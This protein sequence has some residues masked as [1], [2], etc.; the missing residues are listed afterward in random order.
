MN[1]LHICITLSLLSFHQV[2]TTVRLEC[3]SV[4][5]TT[6]PTRTW[7]TSQT[8]DVPSPVGGF[9]FFFIIIINM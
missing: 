3:W 7:V 4:L 6:S 8:S 5:R 1:A 2:A 9:V